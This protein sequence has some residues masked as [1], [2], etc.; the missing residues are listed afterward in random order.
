[1]KNDT[2]QGYLEAREGDG[3]DISSRMESH[4]G[5]VQQGKIQTLQ[6]NCGTD[7]GVVVNAEGRKE[8]S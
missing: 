2:K 7:V 5:T 8:G 3:V 1:M 6:T 4:R